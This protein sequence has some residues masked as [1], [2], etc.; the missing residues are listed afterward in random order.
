MQEVGYSNVYNM[1]S[2]F[3][4]K[5]ELKERSYAPKLVKQSSKFDL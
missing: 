5:N 3:T 2:E 4:E 1:C